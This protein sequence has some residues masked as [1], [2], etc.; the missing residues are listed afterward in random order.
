MSGHGPRRKAG[1]GPLVLPPVAYLRGA[2]GDGRW[3][4]G[5]DEPTPFSLQ[6]NW[7]FTF[8]MSPAHWPTG[9]I[10]DV[11]QVPSGFRQ[12]AINV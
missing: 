4:G 10:A 8:W 7:P 9:P 1:R 5:V 12:K 11:C 3:M 6:A 2:A